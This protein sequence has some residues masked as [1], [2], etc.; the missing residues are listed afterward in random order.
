MWS[1][2]HS[3]E[4][5]AGF[6]RVHGQVSEKVKLLIENMDLLVDEI[7]MADQTQYRYILVPDGNTVADRLLRQMLSGSVIIKESTP[8]RQSW[9]GMLH[10][11]ENFLSLPASEE[12]IVHLIRRLNE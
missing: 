5:D 11:E 9:F 6:T 7:S 2:K 4:I 10:E 12:G 1:E 3:E 8:C